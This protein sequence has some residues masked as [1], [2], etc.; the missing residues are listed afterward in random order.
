[1]TTSNFFL[2]EQVQS[3]LPVAGGH[4][5]VAVEL[6]QHFHRVADQRLVVNDQDFFSATA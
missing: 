2:L 3:F 6:K 4:D 1:M 5:L